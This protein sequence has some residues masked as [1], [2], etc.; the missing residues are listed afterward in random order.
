MGW[1]SGSGWNNPGWSAP[2]SIVAPAA[3]TLNPSDKAAGVALSGGNLVITQSTADGSARSIASHTSGKYYCEM[4]VGNNPASY[5][6]AFGVANA[7]SVL[8]DPP[9]SPDTS[10]AA[11][12]SGDAMIYV[13]GSASGVSAASYITGDTVGMAVDLANKRIWFRVNGGDWNGSPTNNPAT[14]TGGA[15][16][17]A[18]TGA[19]YVL[20]H[21]N[22][23]GSTQTMN[24]GASAFANAAPAAFGNY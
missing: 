20:S 6:H 24:F 4:T 22:T 3:T 10:S 5:N 17:S 2:A 21:V 13:A 19:I 7:S 15:D 23:S 9:G 16:I 11:L 12:Y 8:T 14:N 1:S 18:L